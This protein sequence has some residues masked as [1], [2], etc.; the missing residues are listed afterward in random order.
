MAVSKLWQPESATW[1]TID[2]ST[3]NLSYHPIQLRQGEEIQR[4]PAIYV[5]FT[6]SGDKIPHPLDVTDPIMQTPAIPANPNHSTNFGTIHPPKSDSAIP[7]DPKWCGSKI[8]SSFSPN[9]PRV[10]LNPNNS[11]RELPH[12]E[13]D[14]DATFVKDVLPCSHNIPQP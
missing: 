7:L 4:L 10:W 6:S 13:T 5:R 1:S 14:S 3:V 12:S 2:S 8:P 11:E 9:P